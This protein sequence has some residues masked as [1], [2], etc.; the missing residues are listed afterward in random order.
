MKKFLNLLFKVSICI[1]MLFTF[2]NPF[3]A[4]ASDILTESASGLSLSSFPTPYIPP[5]KIDS[6]TAF[7]DIYEYNDHY[8]DAVNLSPS[9]Y[10]DLDL[11]RTKINATLDYN[12]EFI[13][14]DYYYFKVLTDSYVTIT[15][16]S[17]YSGLYDLVFIL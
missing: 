9:N 15:I 11:Y 6:S 8:Y 7:E 3:I 13:D 5:E 4:K 10:Y 16:N 12:A 2:G 17:N 1:S 14:M